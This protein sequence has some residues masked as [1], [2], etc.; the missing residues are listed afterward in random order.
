MHMPDNGA[1]PMTRYWLGVA[2]R[3]H[4]RAGE[5]GGFCQLG[6][7]KEAPLRRLAPGDWIVYYAPR[8]NLDKGPTIQAFVTLGRIRPGEVYRAQQTDRF[9]PYRRDVD[10]HSVTEAPIRPLL[11][12]LGFVP[13]H[14]SWGLPF[15]RGA[16]EIPRT[17]F[18]TIAA[19]MSV[20]L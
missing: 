12:D 18:R 7:G 1:R 11:D 2:C 4:A 10:Y 19:A 6:H 15:R 3:A 5:A 14:G 20:T 13:D 8:E 16:F 9:R 17:D